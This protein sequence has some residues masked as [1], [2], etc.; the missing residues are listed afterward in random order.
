MPSVVHKVVV[1]R[2]RIVGSFNI[3]DTYSVTPKA[4]TKDHHGSGSGN[5]GLSIKTFNGV[6]TTNVV[7]TEKFDQNQTFTP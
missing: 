6:N 5:V 3:G 4:N 2:I 7:D 1:N